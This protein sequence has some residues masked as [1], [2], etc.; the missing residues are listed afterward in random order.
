MGHATLGG[1][2]QGK[3]D[4]GWAD[5]CEMQYSVPSTSMRSPN[6][7][8]VLENAALSTRESRTA[9]MYVWFIGG[10]G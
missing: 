6:F 9:L 4:C 2:S 8:S 3:G 1:K 5:T 7:G 10:S